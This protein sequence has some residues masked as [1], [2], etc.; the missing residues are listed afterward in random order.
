MFL[1]CRKALSFESDKNKQCNLA[2]CLMH[3]NKLT[4]A[5]FMLQ[6]IKASSENGRIDESHA[7]SYERA[8]QMLV[9]FES[10]HGLNPMKQTRSNN[11][12]GMDIGFAEGNNGFCCK[13]Y[14]TSTDFPYEKRADYSWRKDNHQGQEEAFSQLK[15]VHESPS[16]HRVIPR[17]PFT[18]PRR[19]PRS[20]DQKMGGFMDHGYGF[21]CR[22]LSFGSSVCSGNAHAVVNQNGSYYYTG[23]PS[24]IPRVIPRFL[25]KNF[26]STPGDWRKNSSDNLGTNSGTAK[27][28]ETNEERMNSL[29]YDQSGSS[30]ECRNSDKNSG[31]GCML[32]SVV[33]NGTYERNPNLHSTC[34]H[35][36]WADMVEEDEQGLER[37]NDENLNCNIIQETPKSMDQAERLNQMI[38]RIDLGSG[39]LT[40][41][42]KTTLQMNQS[43]TA[44]R[45]LCFGQNH[46]SP[47]TTKVLNFEG[48]DVG[49]ISEDSSSTKR[50]NRLQVFQDITP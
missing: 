48:Q 5:K 29:A 45:S 41:P 4:E 50:R 39:Y 33:S 42:E 9:E 2:I 25:E 46:N 36:S 12:S 6:S 34:E 30:V 23:Y 32:T 38:E 18:Q 7:K 47:L 37:F 49:T 1:S 10:Q 21:S 31:E 16:C 24:E 27:L 13:K 22:K 28:L 19:C 40:Q 20:G 44:R 35:K 14:G 15:R 26:P 43:T 11:E 8:Y 3:M 17:A